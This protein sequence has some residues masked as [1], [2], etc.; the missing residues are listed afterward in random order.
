MTA[1]SIRTPAIRA[2]NRWCIIAVTGNDRFVYIFITIPEDSGDGISRN[3]K[4]SSCKRSAENSETIM[5]IGTVLYQL[6]ISRRQI[7]DN[8]RQNWLWSGKIELKL[9]GECQRNG[10]AI[11]NYLHPSDSADWQFVRL[12]IRCFD[13]AQFNCTQK[14]SREKPL[15]A[16]LYV[17]FL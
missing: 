5:K 14:G 6:R 13:S 12:F 10:W 1:Q 4:E 2:L 15:S 3:M 11:D 9:H 8:R 7:T 17:T 16:K